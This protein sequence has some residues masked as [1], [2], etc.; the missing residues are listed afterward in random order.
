MKQAAAVAAVGSLLP[1]GCATL[2]DEEG[3]VM[4]AE[5]GEEL[6]MR[7]MQTSLL[8]PHASSAL[9]ELAGVSMQLAAGADADASP[10]NGS[11]VSMLAVGATVPGKCAETA[12]CGVFRASDPC[13]C[14]DQCAQFGSCCSDFLY[15]CDRKCGAT[16]CDDGFWAG[17]TCQCHPDCDSDGTCCADYMKACVLRFHAK[18]NGSKVNASKLNASEANASQ[19]NG[20]KV[21]AS[22]VNGSKVNASK[23]NGSKVNA[24]KLNAS[25]ANASQVNGS[26]VNASQVNESRLHGSP[27]NASKVNGSKVNVSKVSMLAV[28][29]TATAKCAETAG[30]GV[31]RA[32]DP[33]HCN[34][35]CAQFDS[36]CSDFQYA[37]DRK[38]GASS[39][40]EEAMEGAS[41]QC[42]ALCVS[43]GSCCEDYEKACV[44]SPPIPGGGDD[45]DDDIDKPP[46]HHP[47]TNLCP[48]GLGGPDCDQE[49]CTDAVDCSGHGVAWGFR[50]SCSCTCAAG[51]VGY[52]CAQLPCDRS[53]CTDHGIAEG[54]RGDCRCTCDR[55]W[56]GQECANQMC[57]DDLDCNGRGVS[58]GVRPD[59]SCS[60]RKE[61]EGDRCTEDKSKTCSILGC[62]Q[63]HVEGNLCQCS[64]GCL[65]F[66]TCCEDFLQVCSEYY[67][68]PKDERLLMPSEGEKMTFYMYRAQ[69]A[70]GT[71]P[72]YEAENVN[73]G[74]IGGTLW[75][76]HNEIIQTCTGAGGVAGQKW[77]GTGKWGD[78]KF[79]ISRIRRFKVTMKASQPLLD[80][81]M[82]FGALC[83]YESGEC[84]GPHRGTYWSGAGSGWASKNEWDEFGFVV[85]C[86]MV[87]KWPHQHWHSGWKYPNAVWYSLAG[88]CPVLSFKKA[89]D[90]CKL[91]MPGGRCDDPTG[92]GNCTYS[93]EESGEIDI[94]ELVGI[95][96]KWSSRA[97]FC[98]QCGSEGSA[99]S[100]GGCG[101]SFWGFS[102]WDEASNH[103]QVK[104]A[105]T[106]FQEKFPELPSHEEMPTPKCDFDKG[107]YGFTHV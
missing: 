11:M 20:S 47:P 48:P 57:T 43:D 29:S 81:G 14:N 23:V 8:Q 5:A 51:W 97:E 92:A 75:Y 103:E 28:G 58:Y 77:G 104:K 65:K 50:P 9:R 33:C 35:Q 102:I 54:V 26:K 30:C 22:K 12:G 99:W 100:R 24:S 86:G 56:G 80:R 10:V 38:C 89:Y 18:A 62:S 34:E 106:M 42:H 87:G 36:C 82:N 95:T 59:C 76:L 49:L 88:A 98:S 70:A 66:D 90:Q 78:R 83:S 45:D 32:S 27:V 39:C 25:E 71:E 1:A 93:V 68:K 46:V 69:A 61:F 53:D 96:P 55:G 67:Y 52:R 3:E 19:V 40:D 31:F 64:I 16:S 15:A 63:R 94:D 84:T 6:Q 79:A 105:L 73:L 7:Q 41:C 74:T 60:C 101:L 91:E 72:D 4:H 107:K 17:A 13:H 85:G 44:L 21:N 2:L 37:C